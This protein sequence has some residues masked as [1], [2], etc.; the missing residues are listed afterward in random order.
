MIPRRLL[1]PVILLVTAVAVA[2]ARRNLAARGRKTG[3]LPERTGGPA[4]ALVA[5]LGNARGIHVDFLWYKSLSLFTEDRDR[6]HRLPLYLEPMGALQPHF[7]EMWSA[8]GWALAFNA[9]AVFRDSPEASWPWIRAGLERMKEGLR[10]NPSHP[11]R[12]KIHRDLAWTYLRKCTPYQDPAGLMILV[13]VR[14]GMHEDPFAESIRHFALMEEIGGKEIPRA[15]MIPHVWESWAESII[16]PVEE[17]EKLLAGIAAWERRGWEW[18]PADGAPN[19][20]ARMRAHAGA[21]V[22][23]EAM[24]AALTA[25]DEAAAHLSWWRACDAYARAFMEYRQ[26]F[27]SR[28]GTFSPP[29]DCVNWPYAARRLVHLAPPGA[30]WELLARTVEEAYAGLKEESAEEAS[31]LREC[32]GFSEAFRTRLAEKGKMPARF[33]DWTGQ[34]LLARAEAAIA[35]KRLPEAAAFIDRI[36]RLET[37]PGIRTEAERLAASLREKGNGK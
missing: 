29:P 5:L 10:V 3:A 4:Q 24:Q 34:E 31:I 30:L 6:L 20:P 17:R 16:D 32:A 21:T 12:W 19:H 23:V 15:T 36:G 22:S 2:A 14:S 27:R 28:G 25:G 35:E 26:F 13:K 11:G 33:A 37:D 1:L 7:V 18:D 8:T 9:A